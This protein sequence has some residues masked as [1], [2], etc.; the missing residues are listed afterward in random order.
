[1]LPF[2]AALAWGGTALVLLARGSSRRGSL[3]FSTAVPLRFRKLVSFLRG[4]L[5]IA[6][7]VLADVILAVLLKPATTMGPAVRAFKIVNGRVVQEPLVLEHGDFLP[8]TIL[9][10]PMRERSP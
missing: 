9:R 8:A 4:P 7:L 5:G 3:G 6:A 1:M 10:L 2:F